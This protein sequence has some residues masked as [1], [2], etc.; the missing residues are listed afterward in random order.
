[1]PPQ[2]FGL[3][4]I[5][6]ISI[7]VRDVARAIAFYR[8]TLGMTFLFEFPGMAFF[9]CG[10]VRLYLAKAERPELDH[11]SIIYYRVP[12]ILAAA[13]AL[14]ERGVTF[15]QDPARVHQDERHELWLAA[16]KDSEGNVLELMSE[17][18]R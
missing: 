3:H 1:M 8:D 17:V 4:A 11:T 2:S 18:A 13:A 5:G 9:D 15:T 7:V 16:F 10:G 14:T 6:Q 12:D